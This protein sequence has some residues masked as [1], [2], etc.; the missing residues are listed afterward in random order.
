ML[1]VC[2]RKGCLWYSWK[3]SVWE[4]DLDRV[5]SEFESESYGQQLNSKFI[6][7]RLQD[8]PPTARSILAWASLLGN[9]FS[10]TLV[11]RLLSGE[12]DDPEDSQDP[13]KPNC[14]PGAEIFTPRPMEHVV[15]GLQAALQAY[16][17]VPGNDDDQFMYVNFNLH[18]TVSKSS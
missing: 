14:S 3:N 15:E 11:Q 10:F 1:A 5:F 9:S 2:H 13:G 17:L 12:F 16:V 7:R 6:T 8:L 18:Q 4:Y